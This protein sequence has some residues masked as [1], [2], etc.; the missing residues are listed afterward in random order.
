[1][2]TLPS[3]KF[4]NVKK[5]VKCRAGMPWRELAKYNEGSLAGAKYGA[6]LKPPEAGLYKNAAG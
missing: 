2:Q 1:L 6:G 4:Y 5:G 3:A